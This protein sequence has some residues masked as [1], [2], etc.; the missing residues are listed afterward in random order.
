MLDNI[1]FKAKYG[2]ILHSLLYPYLLFTAGIMTGMN[3]DEASL[4]CTSRWSING[5]R[6]VKAALRLAM[7]ILTASDSK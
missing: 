5:L 4:T 6:E 7:L 2:I 3:T 1:L